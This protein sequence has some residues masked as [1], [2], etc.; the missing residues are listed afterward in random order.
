MR[1]DNNSW[2]WLFIICFPISRLDWDSNVLQYS[3]AFRYS[4]SP[5]QPPSVTTQMFCFLIT[6][7]SQTFQQCFY[8]HCFLFLS[9]HISEI[10]TVLALPL[11]LHF[12]CTTSS[13][14]T[15]AFPNPAVHFIFILCDSSAMSDLPDHPPPREYVFS[16]TSLVAQLVKNPPA[17][18]KT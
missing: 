14:V 8:T 6:I 16:W 18:W 5:T 17:V 10:R 12:H 13:A 4:S 2:M 1:S 15:S 7:F 11:P 9:Y 3:P